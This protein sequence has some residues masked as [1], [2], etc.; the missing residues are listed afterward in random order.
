MTFSMQ[1][2]EP[3]QHPQIVKTHKKKGN[4]HK[5]M[6]SFLNTIE[7]FK[8]KMAIL[9]KRIRELEEENENLQEAQDLAASDSYEQYKGIK[10]DA[11]GFLQA[12]DRLEAMVTRGPK[13]LD[14]H[15]ARYFCQKVREKIKE[16]AEKEKQ[17]E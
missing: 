15:G 3:Q 1:N 13:I 2:I 4:T 11:V 17:H 16:E 6:K 12:I 9:E 14:R 5:I 7:E 10:V 8:D